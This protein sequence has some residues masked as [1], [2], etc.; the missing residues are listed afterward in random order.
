MTYVMKSRKT[1]TL[2]IGITK[3]SYAL[4]LALSSQAL[5]YD[6]RNLTELAPQHEGLF[7]VLF[8]QISYAQPYY[9]YKII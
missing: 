8:S 2:H 9:N 3:R 4:P 1:H 6:I 5:A 7:H